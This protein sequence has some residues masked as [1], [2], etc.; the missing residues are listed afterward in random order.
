M[1][2]DALVKHF[3]EK[4]GERLVDF[5]VSLADPLPAGAT[6]DLVAAEILRLEDHAARG[7]TKEFP[8]ATSFLSP[9]IEAVIN[10]V[11]LG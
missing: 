4:S 7:N 3:S 8:V 1:S 11:K 10:G 5:K 9:E 2:L 6:P